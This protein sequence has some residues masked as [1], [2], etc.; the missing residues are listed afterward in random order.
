MLFRSG[1]SNVAWFS[2]TWNYELY[3]QFNRRIRRQGSTAD[4]IR[5]YHFVAKDT[6]DVAV[7]NALR[8][9]GSAQ[10]RLMAAL[11][12]RMR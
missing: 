2:P 6:V 11:K 5:I 7:I 1:A 9:K 3:D 4:R 8:R 12:E 10:E